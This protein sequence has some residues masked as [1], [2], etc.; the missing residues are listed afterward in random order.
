MIIEQQYR[1]PVPTP[2]VIRSAWT[3][4]LGFSL[5]DSKNFQG[6]WE[7]NPDL[8]QDVQEDYLR[9]ICAESRAL[10]SKEGGTKYIDAIPEEYRI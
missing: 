8:P 10:D 2:T 6:I 5:Q 4:W 9:I 3:W 1:G 7:Y